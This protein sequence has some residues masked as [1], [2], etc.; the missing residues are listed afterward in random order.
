[1]AVK[2]ELQFELQPMNGTVTISVDDYNTL[3]EERELLINQ[4]RAMERNRIDELKQIF[5]LVP[6]YSTVEL[7][8]HAGKIVEEL[9]GSQVT[10]GDKRFKKDPEAKILTKD[11]SAYEVIKDEEED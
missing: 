2:R 8:V 11:Y 3:L 4:M 6:H 9:Y 7:Y 5:Q 10:F 1:M